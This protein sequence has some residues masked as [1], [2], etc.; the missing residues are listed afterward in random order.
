MSV[1]IRLAIPSELPKAV[2]FR[3]G[4]DRLLRWLATAVTVLTAAIAVLVV[5]MASVV[6]G[7]T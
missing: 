1:G 7:I 4:R 5:A 6:L 2:A 3:A